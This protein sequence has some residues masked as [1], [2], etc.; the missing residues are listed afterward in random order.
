MVRF[1][2]G[3]LMDSEQ[4]LSMPLALRMSLTSMQ[5]HDANQSHKVYYMGKQV[6]N[7]QTFIKEKTSGMQ[8]TPYC[9]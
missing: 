8:E 3:W 1:L 9:L 7:G 5:Q 6:Y 4:N 2:A